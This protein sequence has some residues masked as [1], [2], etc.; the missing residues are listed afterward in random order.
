[1]ARLSMN[2]MTTYRWSFEDDVA[3]YAAAG[4]TAIGVWRQKLSDFGEEK[5]VELLADSGLDVSNLLWAGGFTGSD[6]RSLRDSIDDAAEAIRLAAQ[7]RAACLVIYSGGRAGHTHNHARRL[8]S[9]ALRELLPLATEQEVTLAL[10]PMHAGCAAEWT[11]LTTLDDALALLDGASSPRLQL[12]FDTYHLGR[13]PRIINRLPEIAGRIA[14]VHLG[15]GKGPPER[16]QNRSRLGQ[17]TLPLREIIA[18]LT[19]AGYEG[20]YDVELIGED[21]ESADYG[22]LL[23]HS[24]DAFLALIDAENSASREGPIARAHVD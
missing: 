14:V 16:D 18:A 4:F 12:A 15:D 6:G 23:R 24:R 11:F 17:G 13:D 1:M 20:F 10:E 21:I 5:G 3:H 19:A 9:V 22:E 8:L 2:E 7:L